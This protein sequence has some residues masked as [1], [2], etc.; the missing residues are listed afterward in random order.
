MCICTKTN[1]IALG[2][3]QWSSSTFLIGLGVIWYRD[4]FYFSWFQ[5]NF[6]L[7]RSY[8]FNLTLAAAFSCLQSLEIGAVLFMSTSSCILSLFLY[9]LVVPVLLSC[10][11]SV[12][13]SLLYSVA[14]FTA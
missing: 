11:S 6:Y 4:L 12:N 3:V 8:Q 9:L 14:S 13:S 2:T 5:A 10:L 7:R 1:L